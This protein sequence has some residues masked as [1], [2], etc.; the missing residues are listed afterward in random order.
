MLLKKCNGVA[1]VMAELLF[2]EFGR[3]VPTEGQGKNS[4]QWHGNVLRSKTMSSSVDREAS[5]RVEC[6]SD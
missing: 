5:S 3:A 6:S 2:D 4:S 1:S